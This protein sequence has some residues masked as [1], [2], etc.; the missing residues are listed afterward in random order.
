MKCN[1]V[2]YYCELFCVV[3]SVGH[4]DGNTKS[5]LWSCKLSDIQRFQS[6]CKLET[7]SI[8]ELIN[9][10]AQLFKLFFARLQEDGVFLSRQKL[11]SNLF[12]RQYNFSNLSQLIYVNFLMVLVQLSRQ[13]RAQQVE[14]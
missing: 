2:K 3:N 9:G 14:S 5:Y 11:C 12:P 8:M 1:L 10:R 4:V 13:I 6:T 7:R